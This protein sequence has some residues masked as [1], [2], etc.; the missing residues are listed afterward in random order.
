MAKNL[1]FIICHMQH[2]SGSTSQPLH[3]HLTEGGLLLL[4]TYQHY[5]AA[6][7]PHTSRMPVAAGVIGPQP[8]SRLVIKALQLQQQ[9]QALDGLSE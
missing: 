3:L 5:P 6:G 4:R 8:L 2:V 7:Y 1:A 9:Q